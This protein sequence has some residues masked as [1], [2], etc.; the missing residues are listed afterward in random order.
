MFSCPYENKSSTP[1]GAGVFC[2]PED[3]GGALRRV[4]GVSGRF[5]VGCGGRARCAMQ[6]D[7]IHTSTQ[8]PQTAAALLLTS[9]PAVS[10]EALSTLLLMNGTSL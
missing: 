10:G 9:P 2:L 8:G 3:D 6:P 1:V 5:G 4:W 7:P